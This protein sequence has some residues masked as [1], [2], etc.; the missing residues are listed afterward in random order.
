MKSTKHVTQKKRVGHHHNRTKRYHNVYLPYLPAVIFLVTSLVLSNIRIPIIQKNVLAYATEISSAT[1]LSNTNE[2]RS[3]NSKSNLILNSKLT[4]AAQAKA[5]DMANR[6]YWSH[7][8]PDGQEPW[9]FFDQAGYR[10]TKAGENLAYGFATSSQTISGWMNSMSH[11]TNMLDDEFTEVG[12]GYTNV[13]DY[14]DQGNQTVVVAM[15]GHPQTLGASSPA[16]TPATATPPPASQAST[17]TSSPKALTADPVAAPP[18]ATESKPSVNLADNPQAT[19]AEVAPTILAQSASEQPV[20]RIE[21]L[22]KGRA[23]WALFAVGIMSGIAVTALF[24]SHGVRLHKVFRSGSKLLK[25][26]EKFVFHH[27]VL[28]VTLVSFLILTITLAQNI[29]VIL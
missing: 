12:F 24:I 7:N 9:T 22:T 25:G 29:G 16:S 21:A 28:D 10:Y 14:Q 15:Y 17:P 27:P 5:N 19:T 3:T 11:R 2:Q 13:L 1:L 6:N 26:G 18:T 20:T 8:T 23:P 4:S